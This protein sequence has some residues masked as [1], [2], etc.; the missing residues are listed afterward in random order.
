MPFSQ[1]RRRE[2]LGVL[3]GAAA[4]WPLVAKAQQPKRPVVGVLSNRS[5]VTDIS[6]MAVIRR[7]LSETGFVEGQNVVFDYRHAEGEYDRLPALAADLVR[8]QVAVMITLGGEG[9][10]LAAKAAT[11]TVPIVAVLGTDGVWA[12]LVASVN[13]PGGNL[14]GVSSSLAELEPKRLGLIR[15]LLPNANTIAVLV[16]PTQAGFER[17]VSDVQAAA[18]ATGQNIAVLK[19]STIRDIDTAFANLAQMHADALL[20]T[21]D[22]FFF[23]RA[24]QLVVLA[25]RYAMPTL[26]FRRE[27]AVAGGLMSYGSNPEEHYRVVGT[28]V[29]RILR[30]EKPADLPIQFPTKFELVINLSTARALGFDVPTTLLAIADEVVE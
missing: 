15:E 26:Y 22:P 11:T 20:V 14:T 1:I 29:G 23:I 3:G 24:S 5:P 16:N 4:A 8:R 13:H 19:A 2:F 27:F 10:A 21:T 30:G 18:S 12:G 6:L 17:Q 28:Y 25:V 7:G 9:S